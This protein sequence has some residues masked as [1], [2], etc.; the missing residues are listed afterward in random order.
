MP[1]S[2]PPLRAAEAGSP[3][4]KPVT[5][6][7]QTSGAATFG[8][9]GPPPQ[10]AP[11]DQGSAPR[12]VSARYRGRRGFPPANLCMTSLTMF[13]RIKAPRVRQPVRRQC[14]CLFGRG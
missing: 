6:E 2:R 7:I 9:L 1:T 5:Y 10:R 3:V 14:P 13:S 8:T 4:P 12:I 11:A